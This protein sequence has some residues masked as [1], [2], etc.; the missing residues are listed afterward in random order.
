MDVPQTNISGSTGPA[1]NTQTQ[2]PRFFVYVV[3]SPSAPDLY[4]QRSESEL[5]R[6]AV[7]LNNIPCVS[8]C[9]I[10]LTAFKAA[11]QIGIVEEINKFK[12]ILPLLHIS[13]HGDSEGLKLS[14][15]DVVQWRDLSD[16]LIPINRALQSNL[17][18]A[19]SCCE[20]FS[21][22]R[23]AMRT[24]QLLLPYHALVGSTEKPTWAETAVAFTTFY[25]QLARGANIQ[26]AVD[27]MRTAS[28]VLTFYVEWGEYTRQIWFN[29]LKEFD[30]KK[31]QAE[32]SSQIS[33]QSP[34]ETAQ[35]ALLEKGKI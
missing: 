16:L 2:Q 5:L 13:A 22:I 6:R 33:S 20:G 17:V 4:H 30:V 29:Y 34:E 31:I 18:V 3:E 24:D 23:M 14:N 32:F 21:G 28:G 1:S 26:Q 9:A 19:M 12:G 11:L 25:H 7:N 27:A 8:R 10:S 15:D 35:M